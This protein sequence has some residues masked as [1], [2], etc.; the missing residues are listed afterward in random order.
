MNGLVAMTAL[1]LAAAEELARV[2]RAALDQT[3]PQ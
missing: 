1:V 2:V 3:R